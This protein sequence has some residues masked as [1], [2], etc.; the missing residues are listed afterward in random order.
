MDLDALKLSLTGIKDEDPCIALPGNGHRSEFSRHDR[1][2][3]ADWPAHAPTMIGLERLG[4]IQECVEK[5]LADNVPGDL[6]ET[7]VWRGGACIFMRALLKAHGD[8]SRTVWVADSFAGMPAREH[9]GEDGWFDM[10]EL[11]APLGQVKANFA[12]YG[13]LDEQVQFLSGW[14]DETLA[15]APIGKLALLRL[16]GDLYSSTMT[17]LE[18]L[19]PKV[20]PGGFVIVDDWWFKSCR[21]AVTEY[22]AKHGITTPIWQADYGYWRVPSAQ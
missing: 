22:R 17:A 2:R 1:A 19:Y 7:G 14:F 5:I 13:L 15:S 20:S 4:N 9:G 12:S 6:I 11:V 10:P 3:G 18:A 16:D 8:T 21:E